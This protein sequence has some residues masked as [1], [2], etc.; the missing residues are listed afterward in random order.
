MPEVRET[1]S[2]DRAAEFYDAT[3]DIGNDA[4]AETIEHLATS[5]GGRG[6]LLEI[7]VGTGLLALPLAA[8]G[9]AVDGID[10]SREMLAKLRQKAS[11]AEH[12]HV[13]EADARRL[14]FRD[15]TFGGAY[16]RHVF[17]LIPT[18]ELAVSELCRVVGEGVI[19]VDA[20]R[21]SGAFAELWRSMSPALGAEAEPPGLV[22]SRDGE[23]ALDDAFA[24]S[25][26][27][28]EGTTSFSYPETET[29]DDILDQMKRRSPSFTWAASD[30]GLHAAIEVARSWTLE[31]YGRFDVPLQERFEVR[32]HRYRLGP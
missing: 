24:A 17:H 1:I 30:E 12:V 16:L 11:P 19:L 26:A 27:T 29:M 7:G 14:P 3:R 20:G 22:I 31:R 23:Q 32:W 2:F 18:W 21:Q 9:L 10:V 5:L 6:R 8:R 15:G 28:P 25:G 13:V 4:T